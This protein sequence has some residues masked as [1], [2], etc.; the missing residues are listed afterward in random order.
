LFLIPSLPVF[1]RDNHLKESPKLFKVE[2][3]FPLVILLGAFLSRIPAFDSWWC[4]DDW[5]QLARAAGLISRPDSFPA[6]WIS[7]HLW[8]NVTWPMLGL[9][10]DLHTLMRMG[11][12]AMSSILVFRVGKQ[13]KLAP[14]TSFMGGLLF[15]VSPFAFTPVFWASGIQE[16]LGGFFALL[17]VE[18]WLSRSSKRNISLS[19]L[20][21]VCSV[22]SK[23]SG[24]G[25][26]I[27]FAGLLLFRF[28]SHQS[29]IRLRWFAT[30]VLL[31]FV[32]FE[33]LLVLDHFS[34]GKQD[35]YAMGGALAVFNNVGKFGWWIFS[36]NPIFASRITPT[37]VVVGWLIFAVWGIVG[38][39]F[40]RKRAFFPLAALSWIALSLGPALPLVRQTHPYLAYLAVAGF[41]LFLAYL[42]PSRLFQ[43]KPLLGFFTLVII[44]W[45]TWGVQHRMGLAHPNGHPVD[46]VV[47]ASRLSWQ[48]SQA[49]SDVKKTGGPSGALSVCILQPPISPEEIQ[50]AGRLGPSFVASSPRFAALEGTLGPKLMVG[51][52]A[53]ILWVNNILAAPRNSQ[54]FCESGKGLLY[55]GGNWDALVYA[56]VLD[57][58]LGHFDRAMRQ[59]LRAHSMNPDFSN[60]VFDPEKSQVS[61]GLF[62]KNSEGYQNWLHR[63]LE[64]KQISDTKADALRGIY[65]AFFFRVRQQMLG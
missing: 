32:V 21:G 65:S 33:G 17:S 24:F 48:A 15:A 5:G 43:I 54:V 49:F 35:P 46:S 25:L 50:K 45:G 64:E 39:L 53:D 20:F 27:L 18:R 29:A 14:G 19:V 42:I 36:F 60:F 62:L 2:F 34:T 28:P 10:A 4:L 40:A 63:L 56:T 8:W 7:Q 16:L 44:T 37:I 11:L 52:E 9:N 12:H 26:P 57:V 23:E 3:I 38:L 59:L 47:R 22:L 55:W 30:L 1:S 31:S 51:Q 41:Y 13:A 58:G 61:P 6:R